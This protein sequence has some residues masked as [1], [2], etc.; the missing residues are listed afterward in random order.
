M[1]KH[2]GFL[3]FFVVQ[4]RRYQYFLGIGIAFLF[5]FAAFAIADTTEETTEVSVEAPA[6][7]KS[8]IKVGGAMRVNYVYGTYGYA[9]IIPTLEA[10][11]SAMLTLRY[12]DLMLILTTATSSVGLNTAGMT[13]TA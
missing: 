13:A 6:P 2:R 10:K 9:K 8:P 11:K 4:N 3:N 7:K 12:S 5:T 1:P